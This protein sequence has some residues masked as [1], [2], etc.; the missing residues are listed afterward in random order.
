MVNIDVGNRFEPGFCW[1][2]SSVNFATTNA[3]AF[4]VMAF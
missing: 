2:R 4:V 3:A 1:V